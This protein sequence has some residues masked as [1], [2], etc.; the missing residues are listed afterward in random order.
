M[1][2][3]TARI[4]LIETTPSRCRYST[5]YFVQKKGDWTVNFILIGK[6]KLICVDSQQIIKI[7][8]LRKIA[9]FHQTKIQNIPKEILFLNLWFVS[10]WTFNFYVRNPWKWNV[11]F[12]GGVPETG[13][14]G[15]G[16][17]GLGDVLRSTAHT[18][19]FSNN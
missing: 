9:I 1:W 7:K 19:P 15:D 17:D 16:G 4:E 8:H 6:E 2:N 12:V 14:L 18:N 10:L 13:L 5:T 11:H 3:R